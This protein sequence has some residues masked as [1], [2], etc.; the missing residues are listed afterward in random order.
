MPLILD[1]FSM[2]EAPSG[3][4]Q[5]SSVPRQESNF[6]VTPPC[7]PPLVQLGPFSATPVTSQNVHFRKENANSCG[8]ATESVNIQRARNFEVFNSDSRMPYTHYR[9]EQMSN[10]PPG[11]TNGLIQRGRSM[12]R[13]E[14]SI[15]G[16]Q[17]YIEPNNNTVTSHFNHHQDFVTNG[18]KP[19][20]E[21]LRDMF[22]PSNKYLVPKESFLAKGSSLYTR[23]KLQRDS[24]MSENNPPNQY[25][26][27]PVELP[28]TSPRN[29]PQMDFKDGS[30]EN[31]SNLPQTSV[32]NN[33]GIN[34]RNE[35]CVGLNASCS[36]NILLPTDKRETNVSCA[37]LL[38]EYGRNRVL[39]DQVQAPVSNPPSN[40]YQTRLPRVSEPAPCG[41]R[42]EKKYGTEQSPGTTSSPSDR[43]STFLTPRDVK[44][45]KLKK[46]LEEQ[47]ATLKRL[48]TNNQS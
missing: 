46:L 7:S 29:L 2:S 42:S 8:F 1:V 36:T 37:S 23:F 35:V 14:N 18:D 17:A 9:M 19:P 12:N 24:K 33:R 11:F 39:R 48:K 5:S 27:S 45:R 25:V 20:I 6:P 15:Y 40:W 22:T 28:K 47:E 31:V 34:K 44:V 3:S 43:S 30:C 4:Q 16:Q 41:Q 21:H 26:P 32:I 13:P 38:Q 10:N